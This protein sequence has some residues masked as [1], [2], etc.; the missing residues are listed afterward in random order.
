MIQLDPTGES[1]YYYKDTSL[2]RKWTD[3]IDIQTFHWS[4][5]RGCK[6]I[7]MD[8]DCQHVHFLTTR[9]MINEISNLL[10]LIP[11]SI[12]QILV[13]FKCTFSSIMANNGVVQHAN[14]GI[15]RG[16]RFIWLNMYS[17]IFCEY[18][19]GESIILLQHKRERESAISLSTPG[20]NSSEKLNSEPCTTVQSL[21]S[22]PQLWIIDFDCSVILYIHV[23]LRDKFSM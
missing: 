11:P 17:D 15:L 8:R 7:S 21:G 13:M 23:S 5:C 1:I 2:I 20:M 19:F 6:T 3:E 16:T 18:S 22:K 14:F 10:P 9:I 4:V 12:F